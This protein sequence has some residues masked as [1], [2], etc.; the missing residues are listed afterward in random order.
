VLENIHGSLKVG[1]R[2]V[3][4]VE[5]KEWLARVFQPSSCKACPD[6]SRLVQRREIYD[7]WSRIRNEWIL[8]KNG[9][10]T[11][12]KFHHTGIPARS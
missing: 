5:G 10:A 3:I 2:C 11:A 7:E 9:K 1:G 8:I 4:D 6:G 12:F